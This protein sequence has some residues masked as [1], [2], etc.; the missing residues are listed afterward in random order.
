MTGILLRQRW[1]IVALCCFFFS[2]AVLVYDVHREPPAIR[3]LHKA[4]MPASVKDLVERYS[5]EPREDN[6]AF[7]YIQAPTMF[8]YPQKEAISND[9]THSDPLTY[10]EYGRVWT[11]E[12]QN[13]TQQWVNA[14]KHVLNM[15]IKAQQKPFSRLPSDRYEPDKIYRYD[16]GLTY[17]E[18]ITN[19][20]SV[21]FGI[22]M[23]ASYSGDMETLHQ[24]VTVGL[25]LYEVFEEGRL[26][27]DE[28]RIWTL[29]GQALF[30]LEHCL[31]HV[32]PPASALREWLNIL[33]RNRYQ[34]LMEVPSVIGNQTAMSL[35]VIDIGAPFFYRTKEWPVD[36]LALLR[37]GLE[38]SQY[39]YF[40]R[41]SII[42]STLN[43]VSEDWTDTY[44]IIKKPREEIPE[45]MKGLRHGLYYFLAPPE[46]S[47][48]GGGRRIARAAAARA[49][50]AS[51]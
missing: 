7:L 40:I 26:A 44:H 50:L 45:E 2:V 29:C 9:D 31:A 42:Y 10:F 24:V 34:N 15:L 51:R 16:S 38:W 14:N 46:R 37:L 47:Y 43:Q 33:E 22:A 48:Y 32:R 6:G 41:N 17:Q 39:S 5:V 8:I 11:A 4:D 35:S 20:W 49:A 13:I 28:A 36:L 18:Q 25:R 3:A 30:T 27:I 1:L 12:E 21:V 19:L 23:M